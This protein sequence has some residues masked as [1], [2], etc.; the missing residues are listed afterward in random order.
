M[1]TTDDAAV[2]AANEAFYRAFEAGDGDA[3]G[4]LWSHRTTVACTHPGWTAIAGRASV[5]ESWSG[6]LEGSRG[7]VACLEPVAHVLG[8]VAFVTCNEALGNNLLAATNV[9]VRETDGWHMVHHHAS[10]VARAYVKDGPRE[11][12]AVH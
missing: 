7:R 2:L 1:T 8:D 9:F 6:I 4:A 11:G 3:M 10:P 5:L 12:D